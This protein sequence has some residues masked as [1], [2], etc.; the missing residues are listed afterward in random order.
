MK[1]GENGHRSN[2]IRR[3]PIYPP[4]VIKMMRKQHQEDIEAA[5]IIAE[6]RKKVEQPLRDKQSEES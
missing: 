3:T 2:G 5:R 4:D 6:R 1:A